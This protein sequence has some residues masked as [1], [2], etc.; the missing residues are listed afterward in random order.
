MH[1]RATW[2]LIGEGGRVLGRGDL[3]GLHENQEDATAE[4]LQHLQNYALHGA[5]EAGSGWW[6]RRSSSA[7]LEMRFRVEPRV[8]TSA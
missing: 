3:D 4:I 1:Y 7:D 2:Q 5:H 8:T 6:A